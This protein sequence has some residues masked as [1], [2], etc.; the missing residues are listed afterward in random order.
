[1]Q[2]P[3]SAYIKC[4][5]KSGREVYKTDKQPNMP[6]ITITAANN[7]DYPNCTTQR[8]HPKH[9]KTSQLH[10]QLYSIRYFTETSR[11]QIG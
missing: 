1:M 5:P 9:M 2:D 6:Q 4:Q 7:D 3:L 11:R 8:A 10:L